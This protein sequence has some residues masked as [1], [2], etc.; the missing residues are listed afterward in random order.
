[1]SV[2]A[3]VV[4]AS[5]IQEANVEQTILRLA[6]TMKPDPKTK[7]VPP[8]LEMIEA[9]PEETVKAA[10]QRL[11]TLGLLQQCDVRGKKVDLPT[12]PG[13]LNLK[14]RV[15]VLSTP[16]LPFVAHSCLAPSAH[17]L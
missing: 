4:C 6:N 17:R 13:D 5:Q 9:L 7:Q 1:M 14:V 2:V 10:K 8:P 3:H 16:S 12:E 15:D 11:T